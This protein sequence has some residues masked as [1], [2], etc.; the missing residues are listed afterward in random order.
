MTKEH[1]VLR[2]NG[3]LRQVRGHAIWKAAKTNNGHQYR[4]ADAVGLPRATVQS[5]LRDVTLEDEENWLHYELDLEI[6]VLKKE[7]KEL[8]ALMRAAVAYQEWKEREFRKSRR[9]IRHSE[10]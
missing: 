9:K 7:V 8:E 2:A 10:R 1:G 5:F 3:K 4:T 6:V